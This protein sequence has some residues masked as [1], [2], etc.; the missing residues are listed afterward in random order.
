[1]R[2]RLSNSS[3]S[4]S[5]GA[6]GPTDDK[7]VGNQEC[8]VPEQNREPPAYSNI[9]GLP[10]AT[11]PLHLALHRAGNKRHPAEHRTHTNRAGEKGTPREHQSRRKNNATTDT[12]PVLPGSSIPRGG[13][14]PP[15]QRGIRSTHTA[16]ANSGP[17]G[18]KP[19]GRVVPTR[20]QRRWHRRPET[21][22]R[23]WTLN[24]G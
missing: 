4:F 5:A 7:H 19:S 15:A 18:N 17:R 11:N 10:D 14:M 20:K 2:I 22:I 9:R 21:Y 8:Q 1:M 13:R 6:Q 12:G 16:Y 23:L 24:G 3:R